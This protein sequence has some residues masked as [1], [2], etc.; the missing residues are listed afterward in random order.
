[1]DLRADLDWIHNELEK[2]DDPQVVC[3]I[4]KLLKS[5]Y[6][7]EGNRESIQQYNDE[8]DA[9]IAQITNKKTFSHHEMGERIKR[10]AEQ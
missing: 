6:L 3:K 9:S 10:W 5:K 7:P 4:Q 1:M 8:L 2:V